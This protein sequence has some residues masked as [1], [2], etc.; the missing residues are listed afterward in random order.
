[1]ALPRIAV[2]AMG[3]DV[4]VR[5]MIEGAALA[6]R[7]H[8]QFKFLL[9]GDETA[10]KQALDAHPNLRSASEILHAPD[11]VAGDEKP[12]QALRRARTTSMG[13]AIDAVKSG[14]AGAAVSAGNTGALMAMSKVA[15]RTMPGIDRPALAALVPTLGTHDLVML[16]LGANTECDARNLVQFAIMGAA[17]A[18]IVHGQAEP[19]V[20]LLNIGTEEIKGTD[21]LREAAAMLKE[22]QEALAFRFDGFTEADKLSRGDV[23]VVVTD[24]FT[25]NIALKAME[26]AAR[27]VADLLRRSFSSSLRSKFGFLISKP[28]TELLKHHLDPNNHNG[29]VFLGLNGVVVKSHGSAS[30]LGVAHAVAV[31]ARLLS[32]RLTER[33]AADL[34]EVGQDVMRS[35]ATRVRPAPETPA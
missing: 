11:V 23:D 8:D 34:A 19:R 18:R 35:A 32:E 1:M 27:F 7:Q 13:L 4:G 24:G 21:E 25:G 12:T 10:I 29:A 31:T 9:V 22:A 28:A 3:G 17:Y 6:R 30:A 2:D 5:V 15:L 16:D 33:I 14:A 26:G 20:R